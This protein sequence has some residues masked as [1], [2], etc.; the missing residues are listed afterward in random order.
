[1]NIAIED[2]NHCRKRIKIEVPPNEVNEEIERITSEF[3]KQ[4][5]LPGFRAGKVPRDV[6]S[7]RFSQDIDDET[8][9][10]LVPKAYRRAIKEK[11]LRVVSSPS[12]EDVKFQRG[13]SL[14]FS[15]LVDLAPEIRLPEYKGV[16]LPKISD[17]LTEEEFNQQLNQFRER[18]AHFHDLTDR[19]TQADDFAVINYTTT[20]DGKPLL[21]IVPEATKLAAQTNFWVKLEEDGYLPKFGGQLVGMNI[22]DKKDVTV[23]FPE[24]F[25]YPELVGK[26][27]VFAVELK[28]IKEKHLHEL[29]ENFA[30]TH[31]KISL[32]QL[33]TNLREGLQVQKKNEIAAQQKNKLLE[34]LLSKTEFDL[35]ESILATQTKNVVREIV[36]HNQQRGISLEA[37]QGKK[38]EI[39]QIAQK[40][41]R[42]RVKSAFLLLQIAQKENLQVTQDEMN[43][44]IHQLSHQYNMEPRKLL[45]ELDKHNGLMQIE[46]EL[47]ISKTLDFL[48][49]HAKLEQN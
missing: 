22:G 1:M 14:S 37:I 9:R 11:K 28:A 43:Q 32:D 7:K 4:V 5:K 41:A 48:L 18:Q 27:G 42:D 46:E 31:F 44:R 8:K 39:Y 49:T 35:P 15:T 25:P 16:A 45:Q 17:E 33:K 36:E 23:E 2:I 20:I 3:Q 38:D 21:E 40:N 24:D 10:S 13:L 29:D 47:L 30:Q 12:I 19:P 6:V 26:K 34:Q